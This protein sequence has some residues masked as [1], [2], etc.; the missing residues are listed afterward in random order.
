MPKITVL[1]HEI[2]KELLPLDKTL[3]L[4]EAAFTEFYQ[5]KSQL[6]PAVRE[7]VPNHHGIFGIKS[8]Y[9]LEDQ[10]I[11][12]KAGGFWS[13]NTERH[14]M[15]H[16]STMV[17]FDAETGEPICLLDANYVTI[18]RTA[19]AG[20]IAAKY[21]ARKESEVV[22]VIG[23]GTQAKAQ[24]EGL[25]HLFPI[26]EVVVYSRT[27]ESANHF[28]RQ[29]LEK[30]VA[31]R[32]THSPEEAVRTA[33]IVI[34]TTPSFSPVVQT[35]W[36]KAGTHISAVGSDTIGKRELMIDKPVDKVVCDYWEQ[37]SIMGELQYGFPRHELYA[38]IGQITSGDKIGRQQANE[39]TLFDTTGLSIQDLKTAFHVYKQAKKNGIGQTI[40][41]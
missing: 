27:V 39:T 22:S 16:Q 14:K 17:L 3:E 38:E 20:A 34:T 37:C 11:G 26:K 31:A 30:G 24:V 10:C 6:Y 9:L 7:L 41:L 23:S 33:D 15:N 32:F 28:V 29:L 12:L 4:V 2:I 35:S 21:L 8:S 13:K 40:M 1:N 5:Q 18:M 25:L 36:L 19:A